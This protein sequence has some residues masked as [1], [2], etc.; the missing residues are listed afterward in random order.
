MKVV[1][2]HESQGP[3]VVIEDADFDPET[4]TAYEDD[5]PDA[6]DTLKRGRKAKAE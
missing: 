1:S 4:H 6:P 3:Y 2:T 5:T